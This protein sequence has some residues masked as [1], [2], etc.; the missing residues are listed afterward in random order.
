MDP[1]AFGGGV[2]IGAG[3]NAPDP[4]NDLFDQMKK[5]LER[6]SKAISTVRMDYIMKYFVNQGIDLHGYLGV[7]KKPSLPGFSLNKEEAI[8]NIDMRFNGPADVAEVMNFFLA[9]APRAKKLLEDYDTRIHKGNC[10]A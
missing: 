4:T 6:L 3:L 9:K 10:V 7:K 5:W 1:K 2:E 8:G